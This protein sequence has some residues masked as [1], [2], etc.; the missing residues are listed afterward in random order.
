MKKEYDYIILDTAPTILVADTLMISQLSDLTVYV[1]QVD[2]T[3]KKL[4]T[5][6]SDLKMQGKLKNMAYVI[7]KVGNSKKGYGYSYN[8][9]YDYGYDSD[10]DKTAAKK[11]KGFRL[12]KNK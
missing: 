9:G 4:L 3:D 12:H 8:Y 11:T 10:D 6:S 2:Y 1:T 7:N 5:Y